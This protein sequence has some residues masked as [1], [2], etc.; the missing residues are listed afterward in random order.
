MN[1]IL[2]SVLRR[3]RSEAVI[4]LFCNGDPR[5]VNL[6]NFADS[7]INSDGTINQEAIVVASEV[8]RET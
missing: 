2:K 5:V 6:I 4:A 3:I 7:L 1:S 8:L